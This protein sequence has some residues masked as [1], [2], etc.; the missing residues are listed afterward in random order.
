MFI[1]Q[2]HL[3]RALLGGHFSMLVWQGS[4]L[5]ARQQPLQIDTNQ[6]VGRSVGPS[7]GRSVGP[8]VRLAVFSSVRPSVR[9]FVRPSDP[10]SVSPSAPSSLH[11]LF[12]SVTL[13]SNYCPSYHAFYQ[14]RLITHT[15]LILLPFASDLIVDSTGFVY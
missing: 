8:S 6:S 9:F 2:G 4:R 12:F 1:S 15:V 7:V 11:E 3:A 5:E 10:L 14:M 13:K